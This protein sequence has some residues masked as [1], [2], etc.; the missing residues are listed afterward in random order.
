MIYFPFLTIKYMLFSNVNEKITKINKNVLS[1]DL[2]NNDVGEENTIVGEYF[3]YQ[4]L[5]AL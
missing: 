1:K 3:S 5:R 4:F 2:Y